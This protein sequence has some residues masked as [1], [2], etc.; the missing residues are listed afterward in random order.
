MAPR[1][2]VAPAFF[3]APLTQK[4]PLGQL[5]RANSIT[6]TPGTISADMSEDGIV[7][8][9]LVAAPGEADEQARLDRQAGAL[10]EH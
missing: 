10:E 4:T 2:A 5:V 9:A 3:N 1:A 6:L 8:H 7:M